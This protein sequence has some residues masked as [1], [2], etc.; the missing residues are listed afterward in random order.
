[1]TGKWGK[2]EKIFFVA[3]VHC[4]CSFINPDMCFSIGHPDLIYR[5]SYFSK[6]AI[7]K[8]P[9]LNMRFSQVALA[10]NTLCVIIN[11]AQKRKGDINV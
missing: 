7:Y 4:P 11:S 8:P 3:V 1:V 10:T 9:Y 5:L 6:V 2:F